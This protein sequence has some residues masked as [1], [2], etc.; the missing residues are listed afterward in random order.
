VLEVYGD[1]S[2]S[3]WSGSSINMITT[4]VRDSTAVSNTLIGNELLD[5]INGCWGG[6]SIVAQRQGDKACFSYEKEEDD[7]DGKSSFTCLKKCINIGSSGSFET[8]DKSKLECVG[9]LFGVPVQCFYFAESQK[10]R[11][12]VEYGDSPDDTHIN[13]DPTLSPFAWFATPTPTTVTASLTKWQT[14][15]PVTVSTESPSTEPVEPTPLSTSNPMSNPVSA[16]PTKLT[17]S[18]VAIERPSTAPANPTPS[19]TSS[20]EPNPVTASLTTQPIHSHLAT[21]IPSI[22]TVNPT[23]SPSITTVN[24]TESPSITTV[25]PTESPSITTVNPTESPSITAV[26]PTVS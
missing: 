11:I 17:L 7:G 5:G 16:S 12:A 6:S 14:R 1:S 18:S 23:E 9:G 19:P 22:T 13:Y 4:P 8:Y 15:S 2:E 26:N 20:L 25:N 24:P 3:A 21:E 10:C